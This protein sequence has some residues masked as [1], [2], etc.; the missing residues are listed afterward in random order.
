MT[1]KEI[2]QFYAPVNML[3]Y[4]RAKKTTQPLTNTSISE[5]LTKHK[6]IWT[7]SNYEVSTYSG[8]VLQL[9]L[10]SIHEEL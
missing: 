7:H 4:K 10:V 9:E 3:C 5:R 2:G 1:L 8:S 6:N